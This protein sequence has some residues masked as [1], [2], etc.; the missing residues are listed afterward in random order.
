MWPCKITK[1]DIYCREDF[2]PDLF[3]N[4]IKIANCIRKEAFSTTWTLSSLHLSVRLASVSSP[5]V[6]RMKKQCFL[7]LGS[8]TGGQRIQ[9]YSLNHPWNAQSVHRQG[10]VCSAGFVRWCL[11]F[12]KFLSY[13]VLNDLNSFKFFEFWKTIIEE[14]YYIFFCYCYY[15]L[16]HRTS[17]PSS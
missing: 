8:A 12:F 13:Y 2:P 4:P 1:S 3:T 15:R 9:N 6:C 10:I 16:P 11:S 14:F 17:F 5:A 7:T